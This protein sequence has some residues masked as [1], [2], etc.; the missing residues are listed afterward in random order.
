MLRK[1]FSFARFLK[2]IL[3]KKFLGELR[4][5]AEA[6]LEP[7]FI[8]NNSI[9]FIDIGCSKGDGMLFYEKSLG[10]K[11]LGVDIDEEKIKI[12]RDRGLT[13]VKANIFDFKQRDVVPLVTLSHVIEHITTRAEIRSLVKHSCRL[14]A[15]TVVIKQP[16]FD[17]DYLLF[18]KGLKTTYSHWS[19]HRTLLGIPQLA[20]IF[21]ECK[22]RN[23]IISW[24]IYGN[25]QIESS[26]S[27]YVTCIKAPM[28][29]TKHSTSGMMI[30]DIT[31]F[32]DF[33]LWR[34]SISILYVKQ[35]SEIAN[36]VLKHSSRNGKYRCELI[37]SSQSFD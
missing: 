31:R 27:D 14:A 8:K 9:G 15:D 26:E 30:K 11:G 4:K 21:R 37:A 12:A 10:L 16:F 35:S 33:T 24:E 23:L 28:N 2:A 19:G 22:E 18:K 1:F 3:I 7:S 17:C 34:E 20:Y 32:N 36:S 6:I 29:T 5:Q 13:A 25:D